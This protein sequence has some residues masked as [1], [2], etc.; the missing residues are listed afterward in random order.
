M[1]EHLIGRS[2]CI[3]WPRTQ[4]N[5]NEEREHSVKVHRC[6]ELR[7]VVSGAVHRLTAPGNGGRLLEVAFGHFDEADIVRLSDRYGRTA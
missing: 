1:G 6:L 3:G 5:L 2:R 7:P 4:A